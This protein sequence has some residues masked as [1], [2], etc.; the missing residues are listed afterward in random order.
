MNAHLHERENIA[1]ATAGVLFFGT[2]HRGSKDAFWGR[3]I[4]ELGNYSGFDSHDAIIKDLVEDSTNQIDLLHNFSVWLRKMPI[5]IVCFFELKP[6][7]YGQKVGLT[8]IRPKIVVTETSACID[9]YT[10]IPLDVDHLHSK[11][12]QGPR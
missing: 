12:V 10:K 9:G 4:A 8:G 1:M 5:E 11:P 7:D 6:A 3:I 2:P